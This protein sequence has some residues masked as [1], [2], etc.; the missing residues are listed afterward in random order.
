[1]GCVCRWLLIIDIIVACCWSSFRQI[2]VLDTADQ[3]SIGLSITPWRCTGCMDVYIY[4][5]LALSPDGQLLF[6]ATTLMR[7]QSLC[8]ELESNPKLFWMW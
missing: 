7:V 2:T 5:C 3:L 6:S 8:I 1:M 4:M